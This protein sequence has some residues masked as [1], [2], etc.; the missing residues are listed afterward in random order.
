MATPYLKGLHLMLAFQHPR[1]EEFGWKMANKEWAA[2]VFE[3]VEN[4]KLTAGEAASMSRS[5]VKLSL[6]EVEEGESVGPPR[7]IQR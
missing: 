6:F 4:G 5:A 2:Y 1:Q 3:S 7:T